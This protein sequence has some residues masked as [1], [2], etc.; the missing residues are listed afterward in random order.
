MGL[1]LLKVFFDKSLSLV[2]KWTSPGGHIKLFTAQ[3]QQI[4]IKGHWQ[5]KFL[6][7]IFKRL[8]YVTIEIALINHQTFSST[9][10]LQSNLI[11][12]PPP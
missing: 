2:G 5:Q 8:D 9:N 10:Y 4:T 1:D 7:A 3:S 12:C 11:F 6:S